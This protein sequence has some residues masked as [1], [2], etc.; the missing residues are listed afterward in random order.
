VDGLVQ[1][2][3][4]AALGGEFQ[5]AF[6]LGAESCSDCFRAVQIL[7]LAHVSSLWRACAQEG[8]FSHMF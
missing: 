5:F 7:I 1:G 2:I 8:V 3:E 6:A 4:D